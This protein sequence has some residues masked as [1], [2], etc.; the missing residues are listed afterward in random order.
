MTYMTCSKDA[1]RV[2]LLK[3]YV[4]QAVL[5]YTRYLVGGAYCRCSSLSSSENAEV[6]IIQRTWI[7]Y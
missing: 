5:V 6:Y 4:F 2:P 3:Q 7:C 1:G